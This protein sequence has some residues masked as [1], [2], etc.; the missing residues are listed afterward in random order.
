MS[1]G[2]NPKEVKGCEPVPAGI[3][4]KVEAKMKEGYNFRQALQLVLEP[5]SEKKSK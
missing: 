3:S 5:D 1:K 2:L 4:S